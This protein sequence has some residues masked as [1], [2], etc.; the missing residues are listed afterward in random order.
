MPLHVSSTMCSKHV[1]AYNKLLIKQD[2]ALSW[3]I[4]KIKTVKL[5]H[6]LEYG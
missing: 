6:I 5:F 3:L 2:C 4:T 1:E